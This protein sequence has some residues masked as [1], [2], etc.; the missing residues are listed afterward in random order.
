MTAHSSGETLMGQILYNLWSNPML[1][2]P[3]YNTDIMLNE[4]IRHE[5]FSGKFRH[6]TRSLTIRRLKMDSFQWSSG[7][8]S[9]SHQNRECCYAVY[10]KH[11]RRQQ[12]LQRLQTLLRTGLTGKTT[13]DDD[14]AAKR[15][16]RKIPAGRGK[17]RRGGEARSTVLQPA[18]RRLFVGGR[19]RERGGTNQRTNERKRKTAIC[20]DIY[21]SLPSSS[22]SPS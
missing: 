14:T 10:S 15:R 17:R 11:R 12:Q 1:V 13:N 20:R 4:A 6:E 22:L 16:K 3:Y 19:R 8:H 18:L 9:R 2:T 7:G 21:R 5:S